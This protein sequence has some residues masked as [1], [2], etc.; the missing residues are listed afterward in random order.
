MGVRMMR[1]ALRKAIRAEQREAAV[2]CTAFPDAAFHPQMP[3]M[4]LNDSPRDIEA[5]AQTRICAHSR[6]IRLI[7]P[8]EDALLVLRSNADAEIPHGYRSRFMI[9]A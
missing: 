6:V 5:N 9:A 4:P 7:E 1:V 3:V 2:K 8:L